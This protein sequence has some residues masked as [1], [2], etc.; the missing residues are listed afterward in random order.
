MS[1]FNSKRQ[2]LNPTNKLKEGLDKFNSKKKLLNIFSQTIH[3][4][5]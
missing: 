5:L 3:M 4:V 1:T 2:K